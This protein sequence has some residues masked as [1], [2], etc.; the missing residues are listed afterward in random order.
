[1]SSSTKQLLLSPKN[2]KV[3]IIDVIFLVKVHQNLK[4]FQKSNNDKNESPIKNFTDNVTHRYQYVTCTETNIIQIKKYHSQ[5]QV[6][7]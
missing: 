6:N 5:V 4:I 2:A 1:M 3:H 7:S